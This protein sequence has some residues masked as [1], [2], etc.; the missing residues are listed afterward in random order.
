MGK[1]NRLRLCPIIVSVL[2]FALDG[3][4]SGRAAVPSGSREPLSGA[5]HG[6]V[7]GAGKP[8]L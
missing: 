8:V 5:L 7:R 3:P 2:V 6:H 1:R 4:S